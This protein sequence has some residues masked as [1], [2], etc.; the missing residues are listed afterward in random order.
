MK[1]IFIALALL[2][3][4][5]ASNAL[6]I[7]DVGTAGSQFLKIGP[8]PRAVGMGE[9][10]IALINDA[11]AIF[12]N[13][14]GLAGL[15][16]PVIGFA[17]VQWIIDI[18]LNSVYAAMPAFKGVIGASVIA[19]SM[20]DILVRTVEDP[21]ASR[22][23]KFGASSLA[24]SLAYAMRL[25]DRFSVGLNFKGITERISNESAST[26]AF[27][28]GTLYDTGFNGLRIGMSMSNFGPDLEMKGSELLVDYEP[29][30]EWDRYPDVPSNLDV[31]PYR[32][33]LTFKIGLAY[34][35]MRTEDSYLT[36]AL[37]GKHPTDN[38]E[39]AAIGVEYMIIPMFTL[40][41]G[42]KINYDEESLSAGASFATQIG[43]NNYYLD[44]AYSL[45][46]NL[47]GIHRFGFAIG[48]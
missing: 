47:G 36:I 8:T 29:Y 32:L 34:D 19:L 13:P 2:V 9:A 25:S 41:A 31:D 12:Y 28:V 5:V 7:S 39:Q 16:V 15:E 45:M 42:Y 44:Y 37:E 35:L 26:I 3:S 1:K 6:G 30:P 27:D 40:R 38:D 24:L 22:G 17:N 23:D 4:L 18:Q 21:E 43:R 20:E 10:C 48:F 11:S 14:A 33:P 46:G